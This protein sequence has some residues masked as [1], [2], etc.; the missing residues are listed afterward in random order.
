MVYQRWRRKV[1]AW[2]EVRPME[3]PG[4]GSRLLDPLPTEWNRLVTGLALSIADEISRPYALFGHSLGALVAFE[5][6]HRLRAS[7]LPPACA[8]IVSAAQAPGCRDR[9]RFE[10][11]ESD[12]QLCAEL[13]RLNGTDALVFASE[14]LMA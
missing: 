4:R 8:L 2:L 11:L 9:L 3:M 5:V 12:E 13:R 1:P 14:E 10:N 7:G 6:A